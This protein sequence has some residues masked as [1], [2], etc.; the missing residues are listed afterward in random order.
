[1]WRSRALPSRATRIGRTARETTAQN[2]LGMRVLVVDDEV[3]MATLVAR[4]L[5]GEGYEVDI[6]SDGIR[7]MMLAGEQ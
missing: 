2:G 4:G 1:M 7:A 3:E 5:V 6:A